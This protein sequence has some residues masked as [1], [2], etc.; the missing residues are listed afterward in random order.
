MQQRIL[1]IDIALV[2]LAFLPACQSVN[3]EYLDNK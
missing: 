2:A 3:Q 1:G